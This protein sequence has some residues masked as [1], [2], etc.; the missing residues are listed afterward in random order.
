MPLL[1]YPA[2]IRWPLSCAPSSSAGRQLLN[3]VASPAEDDG[4]QLK[5]SPRSA[6]AGAGTQAGD[7]QPGAADSGA[8]GHEIRPWKTSRWSA[9]R[10]WAAS[11]RP[12]RPPSANATPWWNWPPRCF[13]ATP[14][15]S[16]SLRQAGAMPLLTWGLLAMSPIACRSPTA[17]GRAGATVALAGSDRQPF[18]PL[19]QL[20]TMRCSARCSAT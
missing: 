10:R 16:A 17:A 5:A 4:A 20:P 7:L 8:P 3:V 1:D 6:R 19:R 2:S 12:A 18:R 14:G 15:I 9:T 11:A 13:P